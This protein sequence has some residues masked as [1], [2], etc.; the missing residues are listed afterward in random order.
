MPSFGRQKDG[1]WVV[2]KNTVALTLALPFAL[3][4]DEK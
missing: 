4:V 1:G 3:K 2:Q